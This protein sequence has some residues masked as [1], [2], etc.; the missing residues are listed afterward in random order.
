MF[1]EPTLNLYV[2]GMA[3]EQVQRTKLLGVIV[4]RKLS[5][6]QHIDGVVNK[7]GRGL[8]VIRR[9]SI[10]LPKNEMSLK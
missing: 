8:S 4:D 2:G 10:F 9:C 6:S 3:V 1:N 7:M 5:W